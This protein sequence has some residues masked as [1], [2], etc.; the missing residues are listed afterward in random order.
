MERKEFVI[1][2][3]EAQN[4]SYTREH[5]RGREY[6]A[7]H[8]RHDGHGDAEFTH[9][10]VWQDDY[11]D[12]QLACIVSAFGYDSLDDYLEQMGIPKTDAGYIDRTSEAWMEHSRELAAFIAESTRGNMMSAER[13][14]MLADEIIKG[15]RRHE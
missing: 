15:V 7:L 6:E 5:V 3:D 13:A 12:Y 9:T 1:F 10:Y 8:V 4:Y 14:D 2:T 11:Q